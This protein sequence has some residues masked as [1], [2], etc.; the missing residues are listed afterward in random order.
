MTRAPLARGDDGSGNRYPRRSFAVCNTCGLQH[1]PA[2]ACPGNPDDVPAALIVP[3]PER[4]D[5]P[6][7]GDE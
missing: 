6:C 1:H 5:P 3:T 2:L 4:F 7:E